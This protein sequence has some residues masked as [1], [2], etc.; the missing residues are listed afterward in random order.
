M[1]TE[2]RKAYL[3]EW[4]Q[5][6]REKVRAAQKKYYDA[7]RNECVARVVACKKAKPEMYKKLQAKWT[8]ENKDQV[9]EKRRAYYAKNSATETCILLLSKI[10][11]DVLVNFLA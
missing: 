2:Q 9:L 5:R 1:L 6:N 8:S 4:R 10:H 7:N 3:A 11:L